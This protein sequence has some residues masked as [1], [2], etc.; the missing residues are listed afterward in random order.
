MFYF[1]N[2]GI[3]P[4]KSGIEHAEMKRLALF[5]AHQQAAQIVTRFFSLSLHQ[6][7]ADAGIADEDSVNLFDFIQ[8]T[9]TF[10]P[11]KT[12][13]D[14]LVFPASWKHKVNNGVNEFFDGN[15]LMARV[16]LFDQKTKAVSN[17]QY[18][19]Q[20]GRVV[21]S[22]WWDTRGFK[23]LEQM[24]GSN[25]H[26][27]T[28]QVL[29]PAGQPVYQTSHM[30][31]RQG[32]EHNTLYRWLDYKGQDW[33]FTGE[34]EMTRFFYDELNRR[35]GEHNV[36]VVDRTYEL[37]YPL[38]R[39]R[40]AA[41]KLMHL[42]SNH[43]N[44]PDE[45]Q[46]ATL[47]FN[48][49]MAINNLSDWD[50]VI[51]AT[52]EQT[53]DFTKRYGDEVPVYTIPVGIVPAAVSDAPR[54]DWSARKRGQVIVVAR[55]SEEKQQNQIVTAFKQVHE[56]VPYATLEFWGYANGNT[57]TEL[58][59]QVASL[60]LGAVV[61]FNDYTIDIGAVYDQAQLALLTSRAEGFALSLLEG[62]SHGVPQIAYD[63]KYGPRDIIRDQ[64][65]GLL[66]TL[67]DVDALANAIVELLNDEPRLKRYSEQAYQ[68]SE[69]YS[70]T[71]V[72][73]RWQKL[74]SDAKKQGANLQ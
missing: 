59:D 37:T 48:Y 8:G 28:E 61:H 31:D 45:P 3:N 65:D 32:K 60:D 63:V 64:Q 39:M 14:D 21:K 4:K 2:T 1:L 55:L 56:R 24:Y 54:V 73:N 52:A 23:A 67:N 22:D 5:N 70:E 47:N 50:G 41:V 16:N 38:L 12:T 72:W 58:R 26:V 53:A 43:V 66:V 57:G 6:T 11:Q 25:G 20:T 27:A 36:F 49:G 34:Q 46:T 19:D 74:I 7:L 13:V 62:Q 10:T 40:T 69:R 42:H 35:N 18:F 68:D 9:E 29:N 71:A 51:T 17:V 44:N 30:T 33:A 15:Q